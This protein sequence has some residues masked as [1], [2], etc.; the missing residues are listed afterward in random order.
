MENPLTEL[1]TDV[2]GL[3]N[4]D[5]IIPR[6]SVLKVCTNQAS[7]QSLQLKGD[8]YDFVDSLSQLVNLRMKKASKSFLDR[9]IVQLAGKLEG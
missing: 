9:Y 4:P 7:L 1:K 8:M 5:L 3:W 6:L 2:S